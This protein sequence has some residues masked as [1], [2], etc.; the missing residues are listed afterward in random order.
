MKKDL[1]YIIL[2][3]S[4]PFQLFSQIPVLLKDIY[5]GGSDVSLTY[6]TDG[7]LYEHLGKLYFAGFV[8]GTWDNEIFISDGTE[9]GT[10]LLFSQPGINTAPYGFCSVGDLL[11][12]VAST[13]GVYEELWVT[14]GTES[15]THLVKD[16]KSG[17]SSSFPCGFFSYN[18][19][20]YFWAND[21][22]HGHELWTSDG[23]EAGTYMVKNI[24]AEPGQS[25]SSSTAY[26]LRYN[27][28]IVYND[29]IFFNANDYNGNYLWVSD[30]TEGGTYKLHDVRDP[31]GFTIYNEKLYFSST[32]GV[33]GDDNGGLWV[34]DGTAEGTQVIMT[35]NTG[36][37]DLFVA[38]GKLY[39]YGSY[40]ELF[41]T[42]GTSE[43]TQMVYDI[44]QTAEQSGQ[45]Y[46]YPVNRPG[47][48]P[49]KA[50]F[51]GK[52]YFTAFDGVH[53]PEMWVTDGT[54]TGTQMVIDITTGNE[55]GAACDS[56]GPYN[57]IVLNDKLYF[58]TMDDEHGQQLWVTQ[59]T[60]ETTHII[61]P[62]NPKTG[63]LSHTENIRVLNDNLYY[64]A[65]YDTEFG[66]SIYHLGLN[67]STVDSH[68]DAKIN[69]YPNPTDQ[70]IYLSEEM[71][72]IDIYSLAGEKIL[73][74]K[75]EKTIDVSFLNNGVYLLKAMTQNGKYYHSKFVKK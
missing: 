23:T 27:P 8:E 24:N 55:Q 40:H 9:N 33:W 47:I 26:D 25:Q 20:L 38:N 45:S 62:E 19:R 15:G 41:V 28:P 60:A 64:A 49:S 35:F 14:D 66:S 65:N 18:E 59:G 36:V 73:S 22:I 61:I 43:G 21:G 51:N 31:E 1:F 7:E 46:W 39:F 67:M 75:N 70:V 12:F 16:I 29:L 10:H 52:L 74:F 69:L 3:V 13:T 32:S 72:W 30:G 58:S 63:A 4:F 5:P 57:Y 44:N 71:K 50:E 11:F 42:D 34:T 6:S 68:S 37:Q 2:L 53:G 48:K 54:A 17:S 56:C